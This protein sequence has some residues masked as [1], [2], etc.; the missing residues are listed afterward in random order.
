MILLQTATANNITVTLKEKQTL[1]TPYFLFVFNY[2]AD[3]TIQYAIILSDLSSYT[4]RY[5]MFTLNLPTDID[6]KTA[7]DYEYRIFEQTSDSNIDP[8][9]AD[10]LLETGKM[11]LKET[12]TTITSSTNNYYV[13]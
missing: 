7:G 13:P 1:E 11:R 2:E 4:Y 10:N 12:S 8:D 5:N 3:D 9:L 6:I